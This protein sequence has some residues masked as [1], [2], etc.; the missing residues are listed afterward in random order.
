MKYIG[1]GIC[2]DHPISETNAKGYTRYFEY[3][4]NGRLIEKTDR[5]G[6]VTTYTYDAAGRLTSESWLDS[7]NNA[8]NT[9]TYQYDILG[10]LLSA[11]DG[12]SSC[13]YTYDTMNR[14][15]SM[16]I[17][18]DAQMAVFSYT[19]DILGRQTES[20]LRLNGVQ[21]RTINIEY[22]YLGR[23]LSAELTGNALNA[24]A[25]RC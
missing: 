11:F 7:S 2:Q 16:T 19:Y 8:V 4:A 3:D 15:D 9:F 18:F 6:R 21:D 10:N 23:A 24:V 1:A 12:V 5:N 17:M 13:D 14:I 20:S 22:D 25:G